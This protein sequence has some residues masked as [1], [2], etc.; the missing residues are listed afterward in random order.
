MLSANKVIHTELKGYCRSCNATHT[1]S[2]E[3]A[4]PACYTLMERLKN[5][6]RIDFV[7]PN[8][9]CNARCSTDYLFGDARGKMF[10]VMV[11]LD[12]EGDQQVC[13]A[14]SGQ[15]NGLWQVPGW[16]DPIF[17]VASFAELTCD[18]EKIIKQLGRAIKE[19]A[20]L[21]EQQLLKRQ[22][23]ALSRSL[24]GKIFALYTL[25][26]FKGEQATLE[27]VFLGNG[28]PTGT[29][30]CCAPKLLNHAVRNNI[31]PLGIAEF[32][33]GRENASGNKQH[34]QFYPPCTEKCE[35]ILGFMLCGLRI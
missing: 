14:F 3:A 32:Y 9:A 11:G 35:P 7:H 33:W 27:Q 8:A 24:M 26:N 22:R 31:I 5:H 17:P 29:G 6:R 1:L 15:Y 19:R 12:E 2:S 30:D 18:T 10:G 28:I 13:Y 16:T 34:G 25:V 23:K 20:G 4:Y 21:K